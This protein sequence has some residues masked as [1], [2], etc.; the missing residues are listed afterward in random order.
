MAKS[1]V[2]AWLI[3]FAVVIGGFF[4][5]TSGSAEGPTPGTD[6]GSNDGD[7]QKVTLSMKNYNISQTL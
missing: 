1:N 5:I 7:F 3:V 4:Y 6:N 2:L